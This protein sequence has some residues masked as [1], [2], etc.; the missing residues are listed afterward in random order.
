M[1]KID[2]A[3]AKITAEAM[4][5]GN[6][7]ATFIEEHLT[8]ICTNDRVA[9]KLLAKDKSL[10][11]H[12]EDVINQM[13]EKAKKNKKGNVG[14]AGISDS[15][16]YQKAEEYYGIQQ[17]DKKRTTALAAGVIDLSDFLEV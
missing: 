11:E 7:Y 17:K 6:P 4:E 8:E 3:I 2:E 13:R 1:G 15:D 9:E 14:C 16:A 5:M 12:I 10:K